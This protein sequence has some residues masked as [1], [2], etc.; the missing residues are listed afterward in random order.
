MTEMADQVTVT[1]I[2][3]AGSTPRE[4]GARM[5]V[6]RTVTDGTIGGGALEWRAIAHARRLLQR[7]C[8]L[9]PWYRETLEIPLGPEL[10]QCCGG[11][12]ELLFEVSAPAARVQGDSAAVLV[13]RLEA[14][15]PVS[16]ITTREHAR[17]LPLPVAGL[18]SRLLSGVEPR[19]ARVVDDGERRWFVEPTREPRTKVF[20]YGAGHVGREIA[21]VVERLPFDVTWIDFAAD[22]FPEHES[23][24]ALRMVTDRPAEVAQL[25]P[26]GSFHVITTHSHAV[27]EAVVEAALRHGGLGYVGLIGSRTKRARFVQRLGRAGLSTSA[28]AQLVCPIGGRQILSKSP[29]MIA[30]AVAAELAALHLRRNAIVSG[31]DT[32][33]PRGRVSPGSRSSGN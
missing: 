2:A 17:S 7:S 12:V 24:H 11:L 27:D 10:Q 4:T 9:G 29:A 14:G 31:Q 8:S 1:V 26:P 6:T 28:L 33:S 5:S 13:R 16:A 23:A 25:S 22:R 21:R 32:G 30:I 20:L 18:V 15:H 3:T 19:S